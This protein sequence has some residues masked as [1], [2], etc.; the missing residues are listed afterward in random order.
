[1]VGTRGHQAVA[2]L[3]LGSVMLRLLHVAPCPVLAVPAAEHSTD[4]VDAEAGGP[5]N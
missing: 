2:G 4:A 3:V 1:V 5:G